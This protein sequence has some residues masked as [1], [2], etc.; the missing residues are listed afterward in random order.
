MVNRISNKVCTWYLIFFLFENNIINW[1]FDIFTSIYD[2]R[3]DQ[4][5]GIGGLIH[6]EPTTETGLTTINF[7]GVAVIIVA[8]SCTIAVQKLCAEHISR[9]LFT[10]SFLDMIGELMELLLGFGSMDKLHTF[11]SK[12]GFE[13]EFLAH[14]G[15][16]LLN[17]KTSSEVVFLVSMA[18]RKLVVAFQR[19]GVVAKLQI[20]HNNK[21]GLMILITLRFLLLKCLEKR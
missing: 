7:S 4:K 16:K 2:N 15:S 21:V 8:I 14:F 17:H 12:A 6:W 5:C 1:S 11:A 13:Q 19:E 18:W 10:H 3:G 20:F 9:P